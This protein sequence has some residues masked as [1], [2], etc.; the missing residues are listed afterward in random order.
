MVPTEDEIEEAEKH[1]RRNRYRGPLGMRVEHLK[2]W[3][4][5]AKRRKR[6]AAEEG[7]GTTEG[8]EGG[9]MDPNWERLLDLVQTLFREGRLAE[10]AT[11]QAVVLIPKGEKDYRGIGLVE[12]M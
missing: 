2:R 4:A 5:A 1:L 10:E 3:L 12:V 6:G 8:K 7:E 11:W 9:L